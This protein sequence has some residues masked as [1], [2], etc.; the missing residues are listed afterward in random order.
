MKKIGEKCIFQG[1]FFYIF[2]S[3]IVKVVN[4][5]KKRPVKL[6]KENYK[7]TYTYSSKTVQNFQRSNYF[8]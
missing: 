6:Y 7:G 3:T 5:K 8:I 2:L 4:I 1:S